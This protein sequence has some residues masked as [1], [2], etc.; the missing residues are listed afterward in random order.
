MLDNW[1]EAG[2]LPHWLE[3]TPIGSRP[4]GGG[5]VRDGFFP[6]SRA[7][8]LIRLVPLICNARRRGCGIVTLAPANQK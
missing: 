4:A 7:K 2:H 3:S 1:D 8:R 5:W 6:P